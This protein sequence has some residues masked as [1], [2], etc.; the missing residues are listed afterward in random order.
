MK[1]LFFTIFILVGFFGIS[2]FALAAGCAGTGNCYWIG[3]TGN[4]N[5]TAH[6]ATTDGGS[7]TGSVPTATDNCNFTANSS[8]ANAAYTFTVNA[9]TLC[10]D[11]VM[12]GPGGGN[13]VTWAGSS[14]LTISRNLNLS[15]GTSG[16]TNTYTGDITM[17]ATAGGTATLT[18]NGITYA[19]NFTF[20]K[21]G[22]TFQLVDGLTTTG[23]FT[24]T[25][26]TFDGGTNSQTVT[27]SGAQPILTVT[28]LTTFYN[29]TIT[30]A[31]A[32]TGNSLQ[33]GGA[34]GTTVTNM[35]T[36]SD[37]ATATNR[38]LI[39]S[40]ST[41]T[42]RSIT[43]ASTT[44]SNADFMDIKGL[45]AATW[46]LSGASGG[47][48]DCGGN[49]MQA[50]GTAAFTSATTQHWT[51]AS[52][53]NWS[54]SGNWTSRVPLCQDNVIM[55]KAFGTSQTVTAD[56]PRLGASIDWTGATWTTA[57]TW[58]ISNVAG[59]A[60]GMINGSLTLISGLTTAGTGNPTLVGRG[61][62]TITNN[63]VSI[64]SGSGV[65]INAPTGTYTL[66]SNFTM[67]S[68]KT[69]TLTNGTFTAVNG[70]NNYIISVGL[71]SVNGIF[72]LTLGSATHL[73][74]GT[75]SVWSVQATFN[76]NTSTIKITDT[77]NSAI[78]FVGGGK[79]YNNVWF[80]RGASTGKN[81]INSSNTF[82]DFKDDGIAAHTDAFTS[83]TTQTVRTFTVNGHS[84]NLI[85]INAVTAGSA[86]NLTS[87][88]KVC[89]N[90][91]SIKDITAKG[92][93]NFF[94]G[95]STNV[96]GN[97][98]WDFFA[99]GSPFS[100]QR[101]KLTIKKGKVKIN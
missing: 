15:G 72:T 11:F 46:D 6:W 70:G 88:N 98:G 93:I 12:A 17:N 31:V 92:A 28:V 96:S 59:V 85:T 32:I 39:S 13:K 73:I 84:G 63:G 29:L 100:I 66:G 89:V 101:V 77:S 80:S 47:S 86:W 57:L 90:F 67:G 22:A 1:R 43:S 49:S 41:G 75:G 62:Y 52:S 33:I 87:T 48:G 97:T 34:G 91:L 4:A 19:S 42:Q 94:A 24:L 5:D 53:G 27:L 54:T 82:N 9:S 81:T 35:F 55:D 61:A 18:S 78:T 56:M 16:I 71:L 26:G 10:L 37:G 65:T 74:T 25:A 14:A 45:G 40:D 7:T 60:S 44:I 58:S 69:L 83:A 23:N 3:G 51:N 8:S 68:T 76:A 20:N 95:N 79:T 2:H 64:L 38:V 36:V 99:C 30:P 21:V 50:L